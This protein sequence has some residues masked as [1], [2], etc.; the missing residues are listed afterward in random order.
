MIRNFV[1]MLPETLFRTF[2]LFLESITV[3]A[4]NCYSCYRGRIHKTL[5]FRNLR[6]GPISYGPWCVYGKN[7]FYNNMLLPFIKA[8]HYLKMSIRILLNLGTTH[9]SF[10]SQLFQKNVM[11]EL[12]DG[13]QE[14]YIGQFHKHDIMRNTC[15]LV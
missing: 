3:R 1:N 2:N 15:W 5:F 14:S 13:W 11:S 7:L 4:N 9:L 12:T 6:M 10:L 8:S